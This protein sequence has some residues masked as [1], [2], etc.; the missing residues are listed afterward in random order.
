[1]IAAPKILVRIGAVVVRGVVGALP[2]GS[3]GL[4]LHVHFGEFLHNRLLILLHLVEKG[5]HVVVVPVHIDGPGRAL[6]RIIRIKLATVAG[7]VGSLR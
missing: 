3:L 6:A 7:F 2:G 5:H 4:F 1:M